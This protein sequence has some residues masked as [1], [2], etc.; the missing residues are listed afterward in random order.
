MLVS[1]KDLPEDAA[2]GEDAI[3]PPHVEKGRKYVEM[4]RKLDS[5]TVAQAE[6]FYFL[7]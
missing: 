4:L 7:D 6:K 1:S 5:K 2:S 3:V